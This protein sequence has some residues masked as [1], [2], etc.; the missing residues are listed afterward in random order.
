MQWAEA[1]EGARARYERAG[2]GAGRQQSG[3]LRETRRA[4]C[5]AAGASG[6]PPPAWATMCFVGIISAPFLGSVN[7]NNANIFSQSGGT[8]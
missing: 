1:A 8:S 6:A 2:P 3:A 5:A 7:G 4:G